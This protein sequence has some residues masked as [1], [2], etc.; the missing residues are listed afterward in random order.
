MKRMNR[1]GYI[2]SLFVFLI[3]LSV[4]LV[5][6]TNIKSVTMMQESNYDKITVLKASGVARNLEIILGEAEGTPGF[7]CADFE[8]EID[9]ASD[10]MPFNV[11]LDCSKSPVGLS[12]STLSC[13]YIYGYRPLGCPSP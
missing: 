3:F 4:F 13:D 2:Y 5:V 1:K 6:I 12:V 9:D 11:E 8:N 10:G 7:I